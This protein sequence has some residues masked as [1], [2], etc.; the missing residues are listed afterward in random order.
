MY[1]DVDYALSPQYPYASQYSAVIALFSINLILIWLKYPLKCIFPMYYNWIWW[2]ID[3]NITY[4][5]LFDTILKC[6][7]SPIT[8]K[9]SYASNIMGF[10]HCITRGPA[11]MKYHLP[12]H[13]RVLF[14]VFRMKYH[15]FLMENLLILS[16]LDQIL[17]LCVDFI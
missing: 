5:M 1:H 10:P 9:N 16:I 3:L 6:S 8:F 4:L 14:E 12:Y 15:W 17:L 11:D 13:F 7:T 2:K